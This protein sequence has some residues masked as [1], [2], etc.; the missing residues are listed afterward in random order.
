M[1]LWEFELRT[2]GFRRQSE[3]YWRCEDR[4]G[5]PECAHLSVF[6][7]TE[8][9]LSGSR[10]KGCLLVELGSFHVTFVTPT[11]RIHFYYHDRLQNDWQPGG[12]TRGREIRRQG[13]HPH[14]LRAEADTVA[15]EFVAALAGAFRGR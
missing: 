4:F 5:L 9:S 1:W 2:L 13:Y 6:P 3:R 8:Q 12:H 7:W 15:A 14:R 11:G 10:G